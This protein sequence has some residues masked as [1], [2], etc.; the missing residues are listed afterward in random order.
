MR[1]SADMNDAASATTS[2]NRAGGALSK[3]LELI[4]LT[5]LQ[6]FDRHKA[7]GEQNE[8]CRNFAFVKSARKDLIFCHCTLQLSRA[9]ESSNKRQC[10]DRCYWLRS[11]NRNYV[12]AV[13][14]VL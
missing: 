7:E 3:N 1:Y 9:A 5:I 11:L 2:E 14:T 6:L 4:V 10:E 13:V 8:N 12:L